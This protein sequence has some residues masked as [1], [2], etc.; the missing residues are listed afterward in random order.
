MK[1]SHLKYIIFLLVFIAGC[2]LGLKRAINNYRGDGVAKYLEVPGIPGL[3]GVEIDLPPFD[4][5]QNISLS[6]SLKGIPP[7]EDYWLYVAVPKPYPSDLV[8][9]VN[10]SFTV[11]NGTTVISSVSAPLEQFIDT[12]T[13]SKSRFYFLG[14]CA[15]FAVPKDYAEIS[16]NINSTST[17]LNQT[18]LAYV[19]IRRG[20]GK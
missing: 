19:A 14:E 16:L 18:T 1:S 15:D 12:D 13:P 9:K 11:K 3:S 7:G 17:H 5:S 8:K 2:D 4:L 10:F 20:G 6:Y